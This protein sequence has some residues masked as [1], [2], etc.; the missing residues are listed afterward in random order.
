MHFNLLGILFNFRKNDKYKIYMKMLDIPLDQP[1][2]ITHICLRMMSKF[3][4]R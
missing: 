2:H 1:K 4:Q 3:T